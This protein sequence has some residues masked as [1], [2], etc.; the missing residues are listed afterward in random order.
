MTKKQHQMKTKTYPIQKIVLIFMIT[1]GVSIFLNSCSDKEEEYFVK[2][3]ADGVLLINPSTTSLILLKPNKNLPA[4]SFSWEKSNYGN[5]TPMSFSLEIDAINGDFS[6]PEIEVTENTQITLTHGKLNAMVL[7]KDLI[8]GVAA[9]IKV[10]IKTALNYGALPS[11]SK[12]EIITV[13]PYEDLYFPLPLSNE[14]YLQGNA[15]PSNWGYPVPNA[16][17]LTKIPNQAVFTITTQLIGNRNFAFISSN[18]GW[19]NPAYV[20]LAAN[21]PVTGG[22][23]TENG[24]NTTP[25][26]IGSPMLSPP[27]TGMYIITIDFVT[28][29]YT[30]T[31]Q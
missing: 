1:F 27:L 29:N 25:P 24:S 7:S 2:A 26:W 15:V 31:P 11:Y 6:D 22:P 12:V 17:K 5:N 3:P 9:Q 10:R 13:T 16:Q 8:P 4:I 23:F 18:S 14:L 28:G 21:Q 30:V 20:A 19:G